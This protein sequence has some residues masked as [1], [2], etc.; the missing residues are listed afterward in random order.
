M[1]I[2]FKTPIFN[3]I[4]QPHVQHSFYCIII[5]HSFYR[6]IIQFSTYACPKSKFMCKHPNRKPILIC[7]TK[8]LENNHLLIAPGFNSKKTRTIEMLLS[9][10]HNKSC[11]MSSSHFKVTEDMNIS[12]TVDCP[13]TLQHF[14]KKLSLEE[15]NCKLLC[16]KID[17]PSFQL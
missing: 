1:T 12:G 6:I 2:N 16:Q 8:E 4:K 7:M 3:L 15:S 14:G 5:H 9:S 17:R 13:N 11:S 10:K